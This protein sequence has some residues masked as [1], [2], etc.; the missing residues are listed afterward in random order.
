MKILIAE[1]EIVSRTILEATLADLNHR[2]ISTEN[3]PEAWSILE[4]EKIDLAILDWMMPGMTGIDLCRKIRTE[5]LS[6]NHY[7]YIILL[8]AKDTHEDMMEGLNAGADDYIIKPFKKNMLKCRIEVA[9]R[10]ICYE[11]LIRE[12]NKELQELYSQA[13]KS[14]C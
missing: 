10:M 2:V 1:D 11:S 7:I 3:G 4:K 14:A 9:K 13:E 5:L 6:E 12:K 8:T